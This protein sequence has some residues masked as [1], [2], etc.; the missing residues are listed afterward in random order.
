MRLYICKW[1]HL[2]LTFMW[3]CIMINSLII[4]PTNVDALI[5]KIY[6]WHETLHVSDS[7]SVHH[8]WVFHCTHNNGICHTGLL[9]ACKQDQDGTGSTL[10]LLAIY[11]Q[12]YM[13]CTIVVCTVKNFWWWTEELSETCRFSCQ[14]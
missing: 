8:Q 11:Q 13:T 14:E 5:S 10:I 2:F 9:T 12:I 4:K 7:S 3:P 1:E 6:S